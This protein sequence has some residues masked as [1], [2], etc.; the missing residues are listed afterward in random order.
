M[1]HPNW[2]CGAKNTKIEK[3][4]TNIYVKIRRNGKIRLKAEFSLE[5]QD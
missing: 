1:H 2:R 3:F 4:G 5:A